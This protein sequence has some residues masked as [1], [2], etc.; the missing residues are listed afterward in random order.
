MAL[1]L[2]G[3]ARSDGIQGRCPPHAAH[4][5]GL[6]LALQER[7]SPKEGTK[8]SPSGSFQASTSEGFEW[9]GS[10]FEMSLE[11]PQSLTPL[12]SGKQYMRCCAAS[13]SQGAICAK[14]EASFRRGRTPQSEQARVAAVAL[15]ATKPDEERLEQESAFLLGI[16]QIVFIQLI[17]ILTTTIHH[18]IMPIYIAVLL[19]P[20]PEEVAPRKESTDGQNQTHGALARP[21]WVSARPWPW[22]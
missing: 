19:R 6:A 20:A 3:E 10:N 21:P 8:K 9:T 15:R 12:R 13:S 18:V 2:G 1:P 17:D 22:A 14:P 11:G 5:E 7:C 4:S 16:L